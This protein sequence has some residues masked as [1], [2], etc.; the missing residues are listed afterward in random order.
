MA[1]KHRLLV[2]HILCKGHGLCAE[3]FP[4]RIQLDDW[5][6]PIIDS[7]P[8]GSEL[9]VA[10]RRAADACPRLALGLETESKR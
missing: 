10:A 9:M 5:G 8:F 6:Y 3:L 4:E 7:A 2:N 1:L